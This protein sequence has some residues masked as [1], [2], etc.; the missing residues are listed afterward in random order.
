MKPEYTYLWINILTIIF[1]LIFSFHPRIRFYRKWKYLFPGLIIVAAFF[2]AWDM[3]FT[4]WGVWYFNPSLTTGIKIGNLPLEEVL[5]FI[6][7]P[8]AC[9]FTYE[10]VNSVL[11]PEKF[12]I[13]AQII[14]FL[15]LTFL[16]ITATLNWERIYTFTTFYLLAIYLLISKLLLKIKYWNVAI[17]SYIILLIPFFIVNGYLTGMFTEEPVVYYNNYENLGIRM[18]TIPVE[19]TFYG[20][21][22]FLM[23]VSF[24]EYFRKN[25]ESKPKVLS[26]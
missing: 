10:A 21:L 20:L 22:L 26:G 7:I 25:S 8:Y 3:L 9:V 19:D 17:F 23:N 14:F 4:H 11:K 18:V 2:I 1:P 15:L 6:T 16:I 12:R 13:L 24:Y 5:F